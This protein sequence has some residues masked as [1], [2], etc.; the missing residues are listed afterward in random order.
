MWASLIFL[1]VIVYSKAVPAEVV[2]ADGRHTDDLGRA[3]GGLRETD[4][5]DSE[6]DF[7]YL[8]ASRRRLSRPARL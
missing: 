4:G 2:T 5:F 7:A 6:Q 3:V 1:M 8:R